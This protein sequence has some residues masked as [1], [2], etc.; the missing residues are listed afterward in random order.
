V[1]GVS[2][3]SD[4]FIVNLNKPSVVETPVTDKLPPDAAAVTG[5][6]TTD[7]LF[8]FTIKI[9]DSYE[10]P[11]TATQDY[12]IRIT[13]PL[14]ITGPQFT[15]ILYSQAYSASFPATGGF[16]PYTWSL[17]RPLPPGF[18]FDATTGT[19]NGTPQGASY[20]TP[21]VTVQDSSNPPQFAN[22]FGFGLQVWGKLSIIT[23][24]LPTVAMGSNVWL[25]PIGTGGE[26]PYQWS[27]SIGILPPGLSVT[28]P[29][30]Y[31]GNVITGSPTT[32]GTYTFT[33]ALSDGNTGS[34][35]QTTSQQLT[36]VVKARGQ[37]TRND[38]IAQATP[39]SNIYFLASISPYHDPSSSGPDVD[40]YSASAVP[41]SIV[42]T[43]ANPNNDFLQPPEPNS[44]QPV[45]EIV[46]N[47]GTRYQTCAL[48]SSA[49]GGPFNLPCVNS[50]PGTLYIQPN[51]FSFQVP[52]TGTAPVTFFIRVSDARGVRETRLHLYAFR[53][54]R[55]L[56]RDL[57]NS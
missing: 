25:Q 36:L 20:T 13:D 38:T 54:R 29:S 27:L 43:Y 28:T 42:Q 34:L 19:L 30:T 51:Y 39:V 53:L 4:I 12:Q 8:K 2:Y 47:A 50:L 55:Q 41:G 1:L 31:A 37:M 22:Y 33:L 17:D 35:H 56:K 10:T 15:Q 9:S 21:N 52:G 24:S 11:N 49:P 44:M 57:F 6:S 32:P 45:L 18:T 26:V 48:Q 16:P 14:T 23:S 46:D 3:E 40:V 5:V 7:G